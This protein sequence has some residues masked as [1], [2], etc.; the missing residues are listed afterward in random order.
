LNYGAAARDGFVNR[1][2]LF[3]L[4]DGAEPRVEHGLRLFIFFLFLPL[5]ITFLDSVAQSLFIRILEQL[6]MCCIL[7]W[8]LLRDNL[9]NI[10]GGFVTL[11][12]HNGYLEL[13][14]ILLLL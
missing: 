12:I 7:R 4:E 3:A 11:S 6:L 9:L 5:F 2:A 1:M 13:S 8:N 14:W 10:P